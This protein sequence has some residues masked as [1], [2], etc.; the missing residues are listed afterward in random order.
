MLIVK[1]MLTAMIAGGAGMVASTVQDLPE[2]VRLCVLGLV[3]FC[4][5]S[6]LGLILTIVWTL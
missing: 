2:G 5:L 6:E 4:G 1:L 3:A